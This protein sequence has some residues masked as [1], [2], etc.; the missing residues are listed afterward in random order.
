M[1]RVDDLW[2][3]VGEIKTRLDKIESYGGYYLPRADIYGCAREPLHKIVQA[4]IEVTNLQFV[5][6]TPDKIEAGSE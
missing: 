2:L 6:G 3:E 4:L 5:D 1:S